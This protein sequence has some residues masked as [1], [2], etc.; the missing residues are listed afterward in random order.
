M[1]GAWPAIAFFAAAALGPVVVRD[2][3]FLDGLVLILLW[4]ATGAAWN[5][6]G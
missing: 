4:G 2:A 1:R 5:V 3:F 6:A